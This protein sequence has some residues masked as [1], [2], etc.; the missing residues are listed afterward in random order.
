MSSVYL[1]HQSLQWTRPLL[2]ELCEE[3]RDAVERFADEA[4]D[5]QEDELNGAIEACEKVA[6]SLAI[7]QFDS[8][9]LF[10]EAMGLA[11][12]AL[13]QKKSVDPD[14]AVSQLLESTAILPDFLDYLES[15]QTDAPLVVLPSINELRITAGADPL[16]EAAYF[17]PSLD[18]I[19]LPE[20][21]ESATNPAQIRRDYQHA[22]RGILINSEDVEALDKLTD[23]TLQVRDQNALPAAVRRAGWA[24]A[25]VSEAL[26]NQRLEGGQATTRLFARLDVMLKEAAETGDSESL[27]GRA[28]DLARGLL[29]QVAAAGKDAPIA[30]EVHSAFDLANQVPE[31]VIQAKV[32]LAGRNRGLL[33]AITQ[34]AREDLARIK[35]ALGSQLE[36]DNDPD[37]LKEQTTLLESVG[38]SLAM[39]GLDRLAS[40]VKAQAEKLADLST[41][42]D[43]PSLLRVAR[44]LLIVESQLEESFG[45]ASSMDSEVE[46][47]TTDSLLPPTEH[48]RVVR[49]LVK[50]AL[51]DL[52]HA[53][54]LLDAVNRQKADADSIGEAQ[55]ILGRI[56]GA[57]HVADLDDAARLVEASIAIAGDHLGQPEEGDREAL[58]ALAET[59]T[60]TEFYL[61]SRNTSDERGER[62]LDSARSRLKGLGYW[63]E[64]DEEPAAPEFEAPVEE[65]SESVIETSEEEAPLD[66]ELSEFEPP[67]VES[68]ES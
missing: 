62:Y 57:L 48:R 33:S 49:Q 66:V 39:V 25:A 12:T 68:A 9:R 35:E 15:T 43:D 17:R 6:G 26:K 65:R 34:A 21:S 55:T 47:E 4:I 18:A 67:E 28:D 32:Y 56:A 29:L 51:E 5:H 10:A 7:M 14:A 54:H 19:E 16:D 23:I 2:D 58:E 50:E 63:P 64:A 40:R 13:Q 30:A 45:L 22:L 24:A 42:P 61:D 27:S 1:S 20:A 44:E 60:V 36:R 8:G 3:V 46:N 52:A 53:K 59:L 41:D 38:E 11:L 31:Q 37:V